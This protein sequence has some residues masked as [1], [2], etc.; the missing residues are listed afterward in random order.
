MSKVTIKGQVTIPKAIRDDLDIR[1]GTEVEFVKQG[2]F[3]VLVKKVKKKSSEYLQKW[4][5]ALH[6]LDAKKSIDEL[7]HDLRGGRDRR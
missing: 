4:K 5:G 1:A 6:T 7:V 2:D 3:F